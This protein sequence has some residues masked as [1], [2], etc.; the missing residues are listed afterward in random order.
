[1]LDVCGISKDGRL[2]HVNH[3]SEI[4]IN[5]EMCFQHQVVDD[6]TIGDSNRENTVPTM[7]GFVIGLKASK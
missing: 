7:V 1:M 3:L 6:P 2:C 4:P 5:R